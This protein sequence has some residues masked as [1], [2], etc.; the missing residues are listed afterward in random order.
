MQDKRLVNPRVLWSMPQCVRLRMVH[1]GT[2]FRGVR[3]EVLV[4]VRGWKKVFCAYGAREGR[5]LTIQEQKPC[6]T[7]CYM[8]S[9]ILYS[10]ATALELNPASQS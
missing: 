9:N 6:K 8:Q 10:F 7:I 1:S 2:A 4:N 5:A 3:L